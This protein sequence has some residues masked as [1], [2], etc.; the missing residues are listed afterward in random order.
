MSVETLFVDHD[1]GLRV[2]RDDAADDVCQDDRRTDLWPVS[3][4]VEY[5]VCHRLALSV[6]LVTYSK[7]TYR[8]VVVTS[9]NQSTRFGPIPEIT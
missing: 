7:T 1:L 9:I 4:P 6:E 2:G 8:H 5:A 3:D